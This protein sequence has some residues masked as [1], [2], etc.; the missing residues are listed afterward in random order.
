MDGCNIAHCYADV[1]GG[2][3]YAAPQANIYLSAIAD[4]GVGRGKGGGVYATSSAMLYGSIAVGNTSCDTAPESDNAYVLLGGTSNLNNADAYNVAGDSTLYADIF[5]SATPNAND[6]N[7]VLMT[8]LGGLADNIIPATSLNT[9]EAHH[10]SLAGLLHRDVRDT[11]RPRNTGFPSASSQWADAGTVEQLTPCM[12]VDKPTITAPVLIVCD[13]AVLFASRTD[14]RTA[15]YTWRR[16]GLEVGRTTDTIFSAGTTGRY[17]VSVADH[18]CEKTSDTHVDIVVLPHPGTPNIRPVSGVCED[19]TLTFATD[20]NS[21][22]HYEWTRPDIDTVALT[23]SSVSHTAVGEYTYKLRVKNDA[24]VCWSAYSSPAS[25]AIVVKPKTPAITTADVCYGSPITFATV[26]TADKYAWTLHIGGGMTIMDTTNNGMLSRDDEGDFTY[27]L[28]T[29]KNGCW[30]DPS[31]SA[32][33]I[34]HGIPLTPTI[35]P[36]GNVMIGDTLKF[37]TTA[38]ATRFEWTQPNI[39]TVTTVDRTVVQT[40]QG[41]YTYKLRVQNSVSG[42][43]IACWSDYSEPRTASITEMILES[44]TS[45]AVNS[46]TVLDDENYSIATLEDTIYVLSGDNPTKA[47]V[48]VVPRFSGQRVS[49]NGVADTVFDV[50]M[51]RAG[52]RVVAF[53]V[54]SANGLRS[55][56]YYLAIEKKLAFLNYAIVKWGSLILLH[57]NR[58]IEEGYTVEGCTWYKNNVA[59]STELS[60]A[61]GSNRTV[62]LQP[63]ASYRYEVKTPEGLL[64]ST[65]RIVAAQASSTLQAYPNPIVSGTPI[66]LDLGEEGDAEVEIYSVAT[67]AMVKKIPVNGRTVE[68]RVALPVGV[69]LIKARGQQ[70]KI[71]VQ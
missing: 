54:T 8:K 28:R 6:N 31:A 11:I 69:Y 42:A 47:T 39:D 56:T 64:R 30:S 3:V 43:T 45:T 70:V 22:Q 41:M 33:G 7:G 26:D 60:Y 38:T 50:D 35:E 53:T 59:M 23:A 37:T 58:L 63:G 65:N 34:V 10:A 16:D 67:G 17:T 18:V 29:Q 68:L 32:N 52:L 2:A 44:D 14:S 25:A 71:V 9:W 46:I 4:C 62:K 5:T 36:V 61:E 13:S 15:V 12:I 55:R 49:Y 57:K 19:E 20:T 21:Y 40:E 1:N 66:A 48:V 24:D 27:T 51:Q